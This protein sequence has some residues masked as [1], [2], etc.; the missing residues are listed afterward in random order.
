MASAGWPHTTAPG[1]TKGGP[2][3]TPVT[4]RRTLARPEPP[5]PP[6]TTKAVK[7]DWP[8]PVREYVGRA[9]AIDK[10]IPGIDRADIATK[11]KSIITNAAEN[12]QLF[13]IDWPNH[14]LPQDVIRQERAL[15]QQFSAAATIASG[16]PMSPASKKRKSMDVESQDAV[17]AAAA[18]T[19]PPW[20]QKSTANLAERMTYPDRTTDKRQ[21][22]ADQF[23][24]GAATSKLSDL[25]KRK[26]RFDLGN[27]GGTSSPNNASSRDDSPMPD[28]RNGPVVGTCQ[29]LEKSYLRLTAPPK[30][31]TVRPLPILKQTLGM[32]IK[33]W[34][35]EHNYGYICDQFKSL[36]QDLTVQHIKTEFTVRVYEAHARIALEKGDVGEYNQCQTQLRALHKQKLGGC[37]G[38]FTAYRI[39]YFIYT[40]NRT[41]MND[42]LA[43][44]TA[45][46]KENAAVKHAL[47]TR[48]ALAT[49][50][51]HK[52]F[53]LFNEA[54]NMGAYLMDMFVDRERLSALAKICRA[55]KP[56]VRVDYLTEEFAFANDQQCAQFICDYGGQQ[57]LEQKPDGVRFACGKAGN[58]FDIAKQQ[59]FRGVDIKGQI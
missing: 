37:P 30:P 23:R 35:D 52:F 50:N 32:L 46:D 59:A 8:Q 3:Y 4:A 34:K 58:H 41:G 53:R 9:F 49:G 33:K 31:E 5:E 24:S 43:D 22:K 17:A 25:E 12:N 39:L 44:L 18:A 54:P 47:Q 10:P 45:Q 29:K 40:C 26:Q 15:A 20:R 6:P 36:R 16:S 38:E 21:K 42:V 2:S 55:F 19:V 51:Y 11:L 56:D 14:P 28:A 13:T 48:T 27:S 57:L 1:V 7:I